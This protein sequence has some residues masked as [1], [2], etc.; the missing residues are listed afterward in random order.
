M[1]AKHDAL[2][3]LHKG[4]QRV[5]TCAKQEKLLVARARRR[6]SDCQ[7]AK[8]FVF[9]TQMPVSLSRRLSRA[10]ALPRATMSEHHHQFIGSSARAYKLQPVDAL[11]GAMQC[12]NL[13]CDARR[14]RLVRGAPNR[15]RMS[16][17]ARLRGLV[18]TMKAV[19][20]SSPTRFAETRSRLTNA[21]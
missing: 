6:L 8:L 10:F 15:E 21:F 17:A 19:A 3:I 1:L 11:R 5:A 7:A 2:K 4:S 13:Q 9:A 14:I 18:A 20:P 16:Y 12:A